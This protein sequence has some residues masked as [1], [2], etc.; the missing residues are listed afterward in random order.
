VSAASSGGTGCKRCTVAFATRERQYLWRIELPTGACIAEALAAARGLAASA[1]LAAEIPW[2]SAT[3][4]IF[5]ELRSRSDGYADGDRIELYRPL[6]RDP[7][8]R[9]RERVQRERR[10]GA[11]R[12]KPMRRNG[13]P[14]R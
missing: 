4:G 5:G 12:D 6:E 7:R 8:E 3:V 13:S 9:R 1:E 14:K 2:D 11:Q 10:S